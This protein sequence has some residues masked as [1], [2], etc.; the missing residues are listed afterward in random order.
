MSVHASRCVQGVRGDK[1]PLH[2]YLSTNRTA[3]IERCLLK[4]TQRWGPKTTDEPI[5]YGIPLFLDQVIE[6]LKVEQTSK[7]M[8]SRTIS[9]PSGGGTPAASEI[10]ATAQLHAH[11][12]LRRGHTLA[13]VVHDYGDLCQ[14]ITDLAVEDQISIQADE[15]RTLSR[16]LDSAMA[17][18]VTEY[19]LEREQ[20]LTDR[21]AAAFHEH[22]GIFAHELRNLLTT[23]TYALAAMKTGQVGPNGPTG[24]M[25]GRS[26]TGLQRLIDRSLADVR[27][28]APIPARPQLFSLADF[29]ADVECSATLEAQNRGCVLVVSPVHPRLAVDADREML[30][31]AATNLL[32]NAF[33]FT[34]RGTEVSLNAY[35][36]DDRILIEVKDHCGGLPPGD[37]EHLFHLFTQGGQD[38]SGLGLGLSIGRRCVEANHGTLSVRDVPGTGC[39][40]TI[41]LPLHV[42]SEKFFRA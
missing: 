22:L 34:R 32:R 15:F 4:A 21:G 18:S 37:P 30:F 23:A 24:A 9:E 26:L 17:D 6:T 13:R 7:P 2:E 10:G 27:S 33:K 14:A 35:A 11:D 28:G 38:K 25:L 40:F 16:C 12:L 1:P 8:L 31:S 42:C 19:A 36:T 5:V 39:V 3:L 41:D 20:L 29:I